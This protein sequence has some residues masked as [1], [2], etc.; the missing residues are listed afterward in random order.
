MRKIITYFIKYPVAVNV[1]ILAFVIFGII[2]VFNMKSSY[3]PLV[4]SQLI[5]I[6]LFYPGAS[7]AEMEEGVIL[8]IEDNLKG[9]EDNREI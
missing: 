7:P 6:N 4:D 1:M 2:G 5:R 9:V 8:K 3:F